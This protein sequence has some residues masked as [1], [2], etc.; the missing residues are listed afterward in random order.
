MAYHQYTHTKLYLDDTEI[1]IV[2][3][4]KSEKTSSSKSLFFQIFSAIL[5][6]LSRFKVAI[7]IPILSA[8][9]LKLYI[10]FKF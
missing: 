3:R 2:L 7:D 10:S 4:R 9:S 6:A 8:T 1:V 5:L